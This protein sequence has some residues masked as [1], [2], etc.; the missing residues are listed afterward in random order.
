MNC[1]IDIKREGTKVL[2]YLPFD[3][4][5]E[6]HIPKGT[7][8]VKCVLDNV[9][10]KS[11]LMSRGN[12]KFCIFFSKQL[13]KNLGIDG[14][15]KLNVPVNAEL[16]TI[17]S[18]P[19]TTKTPELI[20]NDVLD[21]ISR[22][23]SIRKYDDK[24]IDQLQISTILNVGLCA[25]STKNKRPFHFVVT[26]DRAKLTS[27]INDNPNVTMLQSAAACIIVCGDKIVQ[28]IPEW[29]LAD[30]SAATQNMLLAIHSLGLGGVWCGVKQGSDLYKDI[31]KAFSLPD[32]I[33]PVSMIP[34]GYP[35]E[36]KTQINRFEPGKIHFESWQ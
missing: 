12:G 8:L 34:F 35:L 10:F 16:D 26:N 17:I 4:R 29:L 2:A 7:I 15:E 23:A 3:P 31:V 14:E 25:P 5:K 13:L 32:H 24:K 9:Q 36:K 18:T 21:A 28:G 11:K 19:A 1:I 30:C 27:I 6:F 20:H 22:R 33:R